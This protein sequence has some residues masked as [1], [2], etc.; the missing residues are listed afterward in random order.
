VYKG[1]YNYTLYLNKHIIPE[2]GNF[3]LEQIK[4]AHIEKLF[5]NKQ[6][7]SYSAQH[8]ILV[9]LRSLFKS[10]IKNQLCVNDPTEDIKITKE[11][12]LNTDIF[13]FDNIKE[14]IEAA[15][16]HKFGFYVQSL[17]YS[18]M[19]MGELRALK[20]SDVDFDNNIIHIENAVARSENGETIKSTK[21][22]KD[23]YIGINENFKE[24]LLKQYENKSGD[25]V[26]NGYNNGFVTSPQFGFRYKKFFRESNL[27]YLSPHKCRHTYAT[28]LIKNGVD[29]RTVQ[30]LLGHTKINTTQRYT[31]VDMDMIKDGVNK[32]NF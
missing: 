30:E 28:Y 1:Y 5:K 29:L 16:T 21:T 6:N 13:S 12:Q 20:W 27:R 31:Q 23:R 15:K 14:I 17:L 8:H 2:I 11:N 32:L 19:R 3:R 22:G 7:L 25:Y 24:S 4:P 26:I 18:G 10:A 9:I